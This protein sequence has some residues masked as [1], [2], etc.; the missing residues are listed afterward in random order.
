MK[1]RFHYSNDSDETIPVV[2]GKLADAI[3]GVRPDW[4]DRFREAIESCLAEGCVSGTVA[5]DVREFEWEVLT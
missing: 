2:D 4:Q 1:I 5:D 3:Y